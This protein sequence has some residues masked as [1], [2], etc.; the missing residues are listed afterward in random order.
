MGEGGGEHREVKNLQ[1]EWVSRWAGEPGAE[2]KGA[3]L[4]GWKDESR[5]LE[6][7]LLP[8][9]KRHLP[10]A[11][12]PPNLG[13]PIYKASKKQSK[14]RGS[15]KARTDDSGKKAKWHLERLAGWPEGDDRPL[16]RGTVGWG[17]EEWGEG[18]W[19]QS[20][21]GNCMT[22]CWGGW[23]SRHSFHGTS[24]D[25][26]SGTRSPTPV[27]DFNPFGP[28]KRNMSPTGEEA[29]NTAFY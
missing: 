25:L 17:S 16:S 23:I 3:R 4:M 29:C 27:S 6:A 11:P 24:G 26:V 7:S 18:S 1:Q 28:G 20:W 15:R 9:K 21:A 8:P 19:T 22:L 2:D 5:A 10:S 14:K 12:P 13:N